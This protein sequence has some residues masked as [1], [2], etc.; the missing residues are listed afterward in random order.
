MIYTL[1]TRHTGLTVCQEAQKPTFPH[2]DRWHQHPWRNF[3]Y[4]CHINQKKTNKPKQLN[5]KRTTAHLKTHSHPYVRMKAELNRSNWSRMWALLTLLSCHAYTFTS[6]SVKVW[7]GK[8]S[9]NLSAAAEPV[10]WISHT[11]CH[12]TPTHSAP[13]HWFMTAW[14]VRLEKSNHDGKTKRFQWM[15][16]SSVVAELNRKWNETSCICGDLLCCVPLIWHRLKLSSAP[17]SGSKSLKVAYLCVH[18]AIL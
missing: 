5:T 10:P 1:D 17:Q 6:E 14:L 15:C 9:W 8:G 13:G 4:R 2:R 16:S 3:L 11:W 12:F 7:R 18:Q